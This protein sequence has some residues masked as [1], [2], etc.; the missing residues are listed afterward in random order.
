[1]LDFLFSQGG[2]TPHGYCLAWDPAVLWLH[3]GSDLMIALAYF[4]IPAAIAVFLRRRGDGSLHQ[5]AMLFV[6][7][8][9]ACGLTHLMGILTLYV[10]WYGLQGLAKFFTALISCI[11]AIIVWR[12]LPDILKIP[13]PGQLMS[14]LE[15]KKREIAER[16]SYQARL[17]EKE[18]ILE[19]KLDQLQR[20]EAELSAIL[21]T[22]QSPIL[23]VDETGVI[24]SANAAT[25]RLFGYDQ[26]EL[27]GANISILMGAEHA[28]QH[29]HHMR[30]YRETGRAKIV[31]G[32]TDVE[33][34]RKDRSRVPVQMSVSEVAL[35]DR[36]VFTGILTDLSERKRVDRLKNEFV[37][38]VSHELRTPL[39]AIRGALG[40]L[41]ES[42][43][44]MLS[45]PARNMV[46][47]AYNNSNRLVRLINDILDIEKIESGKISFHLEQIELSAL[48]RRCIETNRALAEQ[49]RVNVQLAEPETPLMVEADTDRLIQVVTN[50]LSNAFKF[51]PAGSVVEVSVNSEG[52]DVRVC[53]RDHG[54]GIPEEF[55]P[56][57]FGRFAQADGSDTRTKGGTGL[58]LSISKSIIEA[59]GGEVGFHCPDDGGTVFHFDLPLAMDQTADITEDSSSMSAMV[60]GASRRVLLVEDDDD[61]IKIAMP[62]FSG[63]IGLDIARNRAE[64]EAWLSRERYDL[65][66][67]DLDLPDGSGTGLIDR[68]HAAPGP[69]PRILVFSISQIEADLAGRI[70][71]SLVKSQTSNTVFRRQV[72]LLLAS[73]LDPEVRSE[74]G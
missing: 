33:A 31:G 27:I 1:M 6:T 37:S 56:H 22:A 68:M 52:E 53:V 35:P 74:T 32:D 18:A 51:A 38:T 65:V 48:L 43:D 14:A 7:F 26:D 19:E 4:S 24:E 40:L 47:I 45:D 73:R 9:A 70:D 29:D 11:T 41:S 28:R 16:A 17:A 25:T 61:H 59:H 54:P 36:R 12:L 2:Y 58:G 50:F 39:T 67:L 69:R 34:V 71:K 21:E 13:S 62:L 8:I 64:A 66:V 3:I 5:P 30:A 20:R 44:A 42:S 23:T 55:R 46:E 57:I 49:Y 10:P 72:E 63:N 15:D 60:D